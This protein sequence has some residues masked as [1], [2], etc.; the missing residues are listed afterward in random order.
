M[1]DPWDAGISIYIF[2]VDASPPVLNNMA[3]GKIP[4]FYMGVSKNRD[5]PKWTVSHGKPSFLDD[6]GVPLFLETPIFI[7]H[8][9]VSQYTIHSCYGNTFSPNI[10]VPQTEEYIQNTYIIY[11]NFMDTAYVRKNPP[12]KK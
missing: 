8:N 9:L 4:I 2:I 10:S 5:T 7:F 1:T 3:M 11:T 12:P 6:L